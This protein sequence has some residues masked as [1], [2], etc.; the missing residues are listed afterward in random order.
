MKF[1]GVIGIRRGFNEISPGVYSPVIDEVEVFAELRQV[2]LSWSQQSQGDG[3]KAKH[4]VSMI[5]PEKD[6]VYFTEV[7]YVIWRGQKW[8]I[9]SI[10]EKPPRVEYTLGGLYNG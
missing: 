10:T 2:G 3:L 1:R 9:T 6:D 5:P 8:S 4:V 7:V